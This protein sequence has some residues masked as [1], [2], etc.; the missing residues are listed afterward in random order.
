VR[1]ADGREAPGERRGL[2]LLGVSIPTLY[3]WIPA[4]SPS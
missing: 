1:L 2:A 3:R 4:N